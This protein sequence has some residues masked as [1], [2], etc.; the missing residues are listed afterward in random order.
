MQKK[1]TKETVENKV[2]SKHISSAFKIKNKNI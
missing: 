2:F 1:T